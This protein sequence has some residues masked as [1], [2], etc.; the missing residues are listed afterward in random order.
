ML[1][2]ERSGWKAGSGIGIDKDE[3]HRSFYRDLVARLAGPGR[4]AI[5]FL[6]V[7][8]EDAAGALLFRDH[9]V[10]YARH[11]AYAPK[12]AH[13]SPGI[14]LRAEIL[15]DVFG[16]GWTEYDMLSMRVGEQEQ[17]HKTDWATMRRETVE[18][19]VRRR[20]GRLFPLLLASSLRRRLR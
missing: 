5:Y 18:I 16:K 10:L 8:D 19:R 20:Y 11:I 13:F 15:A 7:G 6:K 2:L 17:R 4:V 9:P 14:L 1:S 12:F 3:R